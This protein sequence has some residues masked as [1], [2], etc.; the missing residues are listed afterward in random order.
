MLHIKN[1]VLRPTLLGVDMLY[2]NVIDMLSMGI[3]EI[4][5]F[6]VSGDIFG[7]VRVTAAREM[8]EETKWN[9]EQPARTRFERH[10]VSGTDGSGGSFYLLLTHTLLH[11]CACSLVQVE[12]L[13]LA[14]FI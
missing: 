3:H 13:S 1:I 4:M 10:G 11:V 8:E 14:H 9:E 6:S 5:D 12:S 2:S 7:P